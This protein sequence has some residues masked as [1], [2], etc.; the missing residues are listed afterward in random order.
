[1][2]SHELTI[3][4]LLKQSESILPKGL[5]LD[6][7][8]ICDEEPTVLFPVEYDYI[9]NAVPKRQ[10]EFICGRKVSRRLLLQFGYSSIPV[11]MDKCGCPI[12]P[13]GMAGSITHTDDYCLV[14]LGKQSVI[15]SIGIDL[16]KADS[17]EPNL[18]PLLFTD[19]EIARLNVE[20]NLMTRNHL[21]TLLFSAKEALY[22]CHYPVDRKRLDFKDISVK[23]DDQSNQLL[24]LNKDESAIA[25]HTGFS[26]IVLNHVV[27]IVWSVPSMPDRR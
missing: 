23:F 8:A 14:T 12:W 15:P 16:E 18:W 24:F 4:T 21:A 7:D 19:K 25:T 3:Q 1:M 22:K 2:K 10:R 11:L 20:G 13:V 5:L 26:T 6:G 17:V 9:Q 27:S